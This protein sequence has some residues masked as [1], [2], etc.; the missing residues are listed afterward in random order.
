MPMT[1]SVIRRSD[2]VKPRGRPND[3]L[4]FLSSAGLVVLA[5]SLNPIPSRTRPL[6]SPAPMVLSLKTW[7]SRSLP[8]L[9]RTERLFMISKSRGAALRDPRSRRGKPWRLF[10]FSEACTRA[11]SDQAAQKDRYDLKHTINISPPCSVPL[12]AS[13]LNWKFLMRRTPRQR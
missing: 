2:V 13:Q 7:K 6:N 1:A 8:G 12:H 4:A 5:G 9:P 10:V 3:Q 11:R